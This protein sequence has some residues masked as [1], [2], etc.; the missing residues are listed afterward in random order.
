MICNSYYVFVVW[1]TMSTARLIENES[2][3][4]TSFSSE[5]SYVCLVDIRRNTKRH[6]DP[7][8]TD[9]SDCISSS[10]TLKGGTLYWAVS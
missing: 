5:S 9:H 3:L 6:A 8:T 1:D 7:F 4:L 2:I 10:V